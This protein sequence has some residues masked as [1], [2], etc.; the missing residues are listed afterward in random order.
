[1]DE[2]G[3]SI[4]LGA[5][6]WVHRVPHTILSGFKKLNTYTHKKNIFKCKCY[7]LRDFQRPLLVKA[8]LT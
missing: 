1:M 8:G 3:L 7:D 5:E 2:A 4:I 6:W